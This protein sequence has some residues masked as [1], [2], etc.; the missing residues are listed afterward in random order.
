M[1]Y[2][3]DAN[4]FIEANRRHYGMDFCPAFWQWLIDQNAAGRVFSVEKIGHELRAGD[5]H[6]AEW[7]VERGAGFFLPPD[8]RMLAS[9]AAI[10]DWAHSQTYRA[11]AIAAFLEDADYYL[12]AYAHAHGH[13]VAT[14]EVP[15]DG[16]KLIKIPNVCIAF[17]TKCMTPFEMLRVA[18]ARF[19]LGAERGL[20][21]TGLG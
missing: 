7:A 1:A 8:D 6:L 17:K 12:V 3:L 10:S 18:G 21:L 11:A 19:V 4:V 16:V 9:L 5:D 2:L 14:H 13:V 15:S 20:G